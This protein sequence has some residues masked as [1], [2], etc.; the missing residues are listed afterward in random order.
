MITPEPGDNAKALR[1]QD[2]NDLFLRNKNLE[3]QISAGDQRTNRPGETFY[4]LRKKRGCEKTVF[5]AG[6]DHKARNAKMP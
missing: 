4:Y 2:R 6:C 1:I 3:N 5:S